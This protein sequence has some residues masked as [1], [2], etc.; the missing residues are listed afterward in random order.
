MENLR[1]KGN[2]KRPAEKRGKFNDKGRTI[3]KRPKEIYKRQEIGHWE[4]DT[5]ESVSYTHLYFIF[6][7]FCATIYNIFNSIQFQ[8]TPYKFLSP[9]PRQL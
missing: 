1:R 6:I 3:K 2:F 5:V 9:Y 8:Y 7:F 4:G